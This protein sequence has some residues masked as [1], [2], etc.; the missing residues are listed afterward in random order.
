M[1]TSGGVDFEVS[2][3]NEMGL[4]QNYFGH[5]LIGLYLALL[6]AFAGNEAFEPAAAAAARTRNVTAGA[7]VAP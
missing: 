6:I 3:G 5:Q 1:V 4:H 7:S 2:G